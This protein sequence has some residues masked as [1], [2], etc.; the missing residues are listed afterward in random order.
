MNKTKMIVGLT[1]V[2]MM[3]MRLPIHAEVTNSIPVTYTEANTYTITIPQDVT[4]RTDQSVRTTISASKMNMEPTKKINVS[5]SS[6]ISN[7]GITL[8]RKNAL[9]TTTSTV[10]LS[11]GGK[12]IVDD[13]V[14][15][16]FTDQNT[17]AE[18]GTGTLYFSSLPTTLNAGTWTGS[19]VFKIETVNR[20]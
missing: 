12:G 5:I 15:A 16:T 7:G 4:L 20:N 14:V 2:M 17:T 3:G 13:A 8:T 19:I 1:G 18:H 10:S 6:G 11:N 9:D